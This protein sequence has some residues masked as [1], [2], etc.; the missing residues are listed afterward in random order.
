MAAPV[1]YL[2]SE[3]GWIATFTFEESIRADAE[4]S[5]RTLIQQGIQV[6][7]LSGD[8]ADTVSAF[9]QKVGIAHARGGCTP[10]DKLL[11]MQLLQQQGSQVAMIGDGLNDGPILALANVSIAMG[12]AVPLAQAQADFVV[13]NNQIG[14][15]VLLLSQAKRTMRIVKQNLMW[16]LAYNMVCVPIAIMGWLPAWLA[17]L[18]MALSSL[19][20]V[21]N[22][23]RLSTLPTQNLSGLGNTG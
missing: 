16:A 14:M 17:G 21:A 5:I 18:G 11:H 15:V 20:V 19:L 10:K 9:G 23:L 8:Q 6:Q 12:Q 2:V 7:L 13:M 22:A 3:H 4:S 1:V